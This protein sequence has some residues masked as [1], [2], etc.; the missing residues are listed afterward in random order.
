MGARITAAILAALMAVY[1]AAGVVTDVDGETVTV[2]TASGLQYAFSG[3]DW[4]PG[5]VA[6]LLMD[7]AGTPYDVTDDRVISAR[8]AGTVDMLA[9]GPR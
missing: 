5:D 3:D 1:P 4:T 2:T 9:E 7:D 6:A 8:Y